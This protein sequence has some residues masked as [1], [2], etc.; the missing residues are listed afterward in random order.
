M[1]KNYYIY[2]ILLLITTG[3]VY[4]SLY[5]KLSHSIILY[6]AISI[7]NSAIF[8]LIWHFLRKMDSSEKKVIYA[9]IGAGIFFR[10][11]LLWLS[12]IASDDLNRYLWDGRVMTNGINPYRYAPND[13][14]LNFLHTT[15]LPQSVNFPAMKSIYPPFAQLIF[16][17]ANKLFGES[18]TGFKLLLLFFEISTII[19][20]LY[21]LKEIKKPLYYVSLYAL[22]P[23]PIMQF[24]VDGHVDSIGIPLL[25]LSLLMFFKRKRLGFY[26]TS[27]LSISTKLVSAMILPFTI[28]DLEK[29]YLKKVLFAI[30]PL[31]V[32]A[33]S[34]L[35]FVTNGVFP[36]ESLGTFTTNWAFN[37]SAFSLFFS[38]IPNNQKARILCAALFLLFGMYLFFSKKET[39]QKIYLIFFAFFILSPTVH[40]WY[41]CWL[42]AILPICFNW[43]GMTFVCLI[44]LANFVVINYKLKGIWQMD[45]SVLWIEYLPVVGLF[46]WEILKKNKRPNSLN[47]YQTVSR[48]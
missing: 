22:C 8:I 17:C 27:G 37:G 47:Q 38:F 10:L 44:N 34:Y 29:S 13:P 1:K 31:A 40:P 30:I 20:L 2:F 26:I 36:F 9:I 48:P 45:S 25:V 3:I 23:L 15:S 11:I 14:A 24:M 41:I 28:D 16:F 39:S 4:L 35:P 12:P 42:A 7:V 18:Y 46:I 32:F 43:S 21:L 33:L 5:S 6:C 19:L